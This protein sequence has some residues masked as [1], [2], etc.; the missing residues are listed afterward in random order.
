MDRTIRY[1]RENFD[2]SC[3]DDVPTCSQDINIGIE[4][5]RSKVHGKK[6]PS[7]DVLAELQASDDPDEIQSVL[8][9]VRAG[10]ITQT[11]EF[12]FSLR[13][14]LKDRGKIL[15]ESMERDL[16]D[17]RKLVDETV[18]YRVQDEG[19]VMHFSQ[20]TMN[21]KFHHLTMHM[22]ERTASILEKLHKISPKFDWKN[23]GKDMSKLS[24][25]IS[26]VRLLTPISV[27]STKNLI[28]QIFIR[29]QWLKRELHRLQDENN[30]LKIY[31]KRSKHLAVERRAEQIK[32][33]R[34]LAE[35]QEVL[36][37]RLEKLKAIYH[38]N[39][40]K[41]HA[42]HVNYEAHIHT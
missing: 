33:P 29:N 36:E 32:V 6:C 23:D 14:F 42:L 15:I 34:M 4:R 28:H 22:K 30:D 31:F 18:D 1:E 11:V 27:D 13:P 21:E 7:P 12:I 25:L 38:N 3:C 39:T 17:F 26:I 37:K 24:T 19:D 41:I 16:A 20:N 5:K 10:R 35:Q 9:E 40:E 2:E 8:D